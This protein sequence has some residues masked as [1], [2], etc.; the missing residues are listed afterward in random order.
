M[1]NFE[2]GL[3]RDQKNENNARI[4]AVV[5]ESALSAVFGSKED[6]NNAV[7]RFEEGV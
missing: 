7:L 6:M 1:K 3:S 5:T 2:Q 4:D